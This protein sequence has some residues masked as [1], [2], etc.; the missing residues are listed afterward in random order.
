MDKEL[1]NI[2]EINIEDEMKKILSGLFHECNYES[3]FT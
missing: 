1:G 3:C 2:V